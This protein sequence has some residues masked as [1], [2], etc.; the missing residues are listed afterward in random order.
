VILLPLTTCEAFF[1]FVFVSCVYL[2]TICFCLVAGT[3]QLIY[4][5]GTSGKI[6]LESGC[7]T[8]RNTSQLDVY[9]GSNTDSASVPVESTVHMTVVEW[10]PG[11]SACSPSQTF[12]TVRVVAPAEQCVDFTADQKVDETTLNVTLKMQVKNCARTFYMSVV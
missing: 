8:L 3:I 2:T 4:T 12:A 11:D 6:T 10:R 5:N 1:P 9:V 7:P